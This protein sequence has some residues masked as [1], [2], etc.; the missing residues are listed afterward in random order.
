MFKLD[1][2]SAHCDV[3]CGIYDPHRAL[4]AAVSI[5]R[6]VDLLNA[7]Y[8]MKSDDAQFQNDIARY[9][10]TKEEEATLL[11]EEIRIIWGDFVKPVHLEGYPEIHQIVHNIMM[12]GG[13]VK[14]HVSREKALELLEEVN[15]FAVIFWKIKGFSTEKVTT[16]SPVE[17]KIVSPLLNA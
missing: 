10:A 15:K 11:K 5:I 1:E 16:A 2:V 14:Q 17:E 13:A 9:I 6:M 8:E 12:L 4:I 3:P 7:K